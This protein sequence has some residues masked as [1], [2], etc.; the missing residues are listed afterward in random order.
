MMQ[1]EKFHY[2]E[3]ELSKQYRLDKMYMQIAV[4]HSMRSRA[5][6]KKVGAVIVTPQQVMLGGWNG[7]PPGWDNVCETLDNSGNLT[8]KSCVIHAEENCLTKAARE[9]VSVVGSVL[10]VTLPPCQHCA[11]KIH[12]SGIIRVV[13]LDEYISQTHGSGTKDLQDHGVIVEKFSKL[14]YI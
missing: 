3:E 11:A 9:G 12:A 7:T 10:Y 4:L 13:Y 1:Q 14:K 5:Q 2:A 8:T 6:R